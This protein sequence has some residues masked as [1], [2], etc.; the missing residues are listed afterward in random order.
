M[1]SKMV[2]YKEYPYESEEKYGVGNSFE[3]EDT[4][5]SL[6]EEIRIFKVDNDRIMQAQQN[7]E[8]VNAMILQS[9]QICSD[10]D[11][12]G[13]NMSKRKKLMGHMVVGHM[14]ITCQIKTTKSEMVDC[15][16]L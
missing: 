14:V 2:D 4:L 6:K 15:W 11:H 1:A 10:R 3:L 9:F 8:E 12:V 16:T 7:Q 5:R 13:S